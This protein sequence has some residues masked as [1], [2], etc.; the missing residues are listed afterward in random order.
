VRLLVTSG[1]NLV[2][3]E[4]RSQV[5]ESK[6]KLS[7]ISMGQ[8]AM[9][10]YASVRITPQQPGERGGHFNVL[11]TR[12]DW[13]VAVNV[14]G[15]EDAAKEAF[16]RIAIQRVEEALTRGTTKSATW[17]MTGDPHKIEL[18]HADVREM[19]SRYR[20]KVCSYQ[21]QRGRDLF[22]L[23]VDPRDQTASVHPDGVRA[24]PTSE[25][26]CVDCALP[27]DRYLCSNLMHPQVI[28]VSPRN[29][30]VS[31][32]SCNLGYVEKVAA[33]NLC[34]AGGH[35]CWERLLS[36]PELAVRAVSATELLDAFD[37]LNAAWR[38]LFG[39]QHVLLRVTLLGAAG[40]LTSECAGAED[41]GAKVS[42][43]DDL[44]RRFTVDDELL[45][46]GQPIPGPF[47]KMQVAFENVGIGGGVLEGPFEKLRA[48][49]RLRVGLQHGDAAA[50]LPRHARTL[51]IDWPTRD[52]VGAWR[53]VRSQTVEALSS[54]ARTA[55][56]AAD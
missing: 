13:D 34:K 15:G 29:R 48:V 2:T 18:E 1:H 36:V 28:R 22:C 30:G 8:E 14:L 11:M 4:V 25:S 45:P 47:A 56:A 46:V 27:D 12:L 52:Y 31:S 35:D 20:D 9:R 44:C 7:H 38:L 49:N 55:S 26:I 40:D 53:V 24:A 19:T 41:F 32:A 23:A 21:E 5:P 39:K 50:E 17:E 42:A 16:A 54:L 6:Y 51:G 43:L 37:H 10:A 33:P 3:S